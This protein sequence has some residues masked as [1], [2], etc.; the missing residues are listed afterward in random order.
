MEI[1][2]SGDYKFAY[3]DGLRFCRDDKTGYYRNS[4][5][6]KRLHR[7]VWEFYNGEIPQGMS[8][9]LIN[10]DRSCNE[11]W[12][13]QLME[14][15]EHT[16]Y[17]SKHLT[18]EQKNKRKIAAKN[19]QKY[20]AKWHKSIMGKE[21]HKKH[22]AKMKEKLFK[23][24]KNICVCCGKEFMGK[25]GTMYCCN[26]CK[27]KYRRVIGSDMVECICEYCGKRF[28]KSK[29]SNTRFCSKGCSNRGR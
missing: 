26:A 18:D 7:Y 25:K 10:N 5:T 3:F 27:S 19:N 16:S 17:H 24:R 29:Y 23:K 1:V 20:T 28:L 8:V 11:I 13:L 14:S 9:H 22:Y 21:W 6:G 4:K 2:Y 15:G 12:N